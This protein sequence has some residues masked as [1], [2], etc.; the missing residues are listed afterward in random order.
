MGKKNYSLWVKSLKSW[1]PTYHHYKKS[2]QL[3][4]HRIP[5]TTI[6]AKT[7]VHYNPY[8]ISSYWCLI[9]HHWFP[10]V[11]ARFTLCCKLLRKSHW[12]APSGM[13]SVCST[14][15][16]CSL[17]NT[18]G[19]HRCISMTSRGWV[20]VVFFK[21]WGSTIKIGGYMPGYW[22]NL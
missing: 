2:P 19:H 6:M 18:M 3:Q 13:A 8:I 10:R 16:A 11:M 5:M 7:D 14:A 20:G 9:S 12:C 4:S 21:I 17:A 1:W 15:A 22:C